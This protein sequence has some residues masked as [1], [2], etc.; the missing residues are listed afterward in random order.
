MSQDL[1]IAYLALRS[2]DNWS[3]VGCVTISAYLWLMGFSALIILVTPIANLLNPYRLPNPVPNTES[4][5]CMGEQTPPVLLLDNRQG[6]GRVS[7]WPL[8]SDSH[9]AV[10]GMKVGKH[11]RAPVNTATNRRCKLKSLSS[12]YL[13][14]DFQFTVVLGTVSKPSLTLNKNLTTGLPPQFNL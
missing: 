1:E 14:C 10:F 8:Q 2:Q 11:T 12:W 6:W 9:A 4:V 7:L 5:K 3:R 13:N